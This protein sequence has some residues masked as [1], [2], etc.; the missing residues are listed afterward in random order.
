MVAKQNTYFKR[1]IRGERAMLMLPFNVV[2]VGR[3]RGVVETSRVVETLAKLRSRHPM[4]GVRVQIEEDGSA[5]FSSKGVPALS[6]HT[7]VRQD[8]KQWL[9]RVKT[10][11]QTSF[12]LEMGP[13]VRC[14]VLHSAEGC[15]IILCG[16]H[17]VCDGMSLAY[18]LRDLLDRLS[19]PKQET[20]QALIPPPIDHTTVPNPLAI[21]CLARFVMRL[22]NKRWA[23]KGIQFTEADMYRL[24]ERF[25]EENKDLQILAWNMPPDSTADLVKRCRSEKV[26]VNAALWAAFLA[27]QYDLQGDAVAYRQHSAMAVNTRKKLTVP[28]GESFGFYASSLSLTLPYSPLL[29]FWDNARR[30]HTRILEE[31]STTN[32]FRMLSAEHLHPT[33]LDALYY[34]KYGLLEETMPARLLRRMGWDRI[35]YG[36]ALTNVGRLDI[37]TTYGSLKLEVLYGPLFYS[38]VEEKMI[39]TITLGGRLSFLFVSK[40]SVVDDPASLRDTAMEHLKQAMGRL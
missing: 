3:V 20:E 25:W 11:F 37:P 14:T 36:Y 4:L 29:S 9:E 30:I 31:L 8:D 39:G 38:D 21:N 13:L 24:H 22:I 18:L 26:T 7:E 16:H 6:V 40:A 2:L 15:D 27:A 1:L 19:T 32:L 28:A 5:S 33:L 34:Q 17:V 35:T 23:K 10:E 12:P